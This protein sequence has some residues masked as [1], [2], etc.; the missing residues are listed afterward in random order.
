MTKSNVKQLTERFQQRQD[1]YSA[2][3]KRRGTQTLEG[4]YTLGEEPCPNPSP[5]SVE[6]DLKQSGFEIDITKAGPSGEHL[7]SAVAAGGILVMGDGDYDPDMYSFGKIEPTRIVL[8]PFSNRSTCGI[9]LTR[10]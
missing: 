7:F 1:I 3:L 8:R 4:R 9:L 2:E 5:D 6:V 10:K